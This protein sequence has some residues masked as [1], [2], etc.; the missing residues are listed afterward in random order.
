MQPLNDLPIAVS[1]LLVILITVALAVSGLL[2]TRRYIR[3]HFGISD[4]TDDTVQFYAAAIAAFYGIALG[5]ITVANWE[6]Y[7]RAVEIISAEAASVGALYRDVGGYPQPLRDELRA[8]LADYLTFVINTSWPAQKEGQVVAGSVEIINRFQDKLLQFEP[9]TE[10]QKVIHEEAF[11]QYNNFITLRRQRIDFVD[12]AL[13]SILW[14]IILGGAVLTIF[15]TYFFYVPNVRLH[16]ML[17]VCYALLVAVVI[18]FTSLMENPL[19]GP[20]A[21]TPASYQL[22]LDTMIDSPSLPQGSS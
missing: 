17:I 5:L 18:Y 22:I 21:I 15:V 2:V 19:K 6:N 13:P 3:H 1:L 4:E 11:G 12:T 16:I 14:L 10:G 9:V 20:A 7:T 8:D